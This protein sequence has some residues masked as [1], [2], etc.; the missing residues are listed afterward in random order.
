MIEDSSAEYS[1][2]IINVAFEFAN[3]ATSMYEEY[4]RL[5]FSSFSIPSR[6][7][8]FSKNYKGGR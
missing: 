8:L 1:E 7:I 5:I 6:N 4:F 3:F 2:K